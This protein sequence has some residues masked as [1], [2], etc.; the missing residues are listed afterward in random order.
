MRRLSLVAL[1]VMVSAVAGLAAQEKKFGTALKL[2]EA[3]KV[4]EIYA[5]PDK[6]N[7]KRI[8][9]QGPIVDVCAEMGCWLALGSD[10]EFQTIRFKVEDGVMVFPMSVKGMNAKVEGVISV[11]T[12]TEA[13]QI[14]QGEEMAREMNKTFDPKTVK[15]PKVN[16]MIKG[17]GAIVY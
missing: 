2:T 17:E 13:Q 3:T 15:G 6:Y 12:L 7:G 14:A 9:V 10:K 16:V 4:S 5:N 11:A 1:V 8:Q